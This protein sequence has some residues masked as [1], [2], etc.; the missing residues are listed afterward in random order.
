MTTKQ[1]FRGED[2]ELSQLP[3]DKRV[4]RDGT[5]REA[6]VKNLGMKDLSP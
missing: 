2:R 5:R 3:L 6:G 1:S 4:R